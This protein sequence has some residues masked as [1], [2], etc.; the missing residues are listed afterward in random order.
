M[1]RISRAT[2]RM[3]AL[4]LISATLLWA[5]AQ[6]RDVIDPELLRE[7]YGVTGA[8]SDQVPAGE[9]A[10]EA[11]I[12]PITFANGQ[13]GQLI[14][15]KKPGTSA[16]YMRDSGGLHPVALS[17]RSISREEFVRSNPRIVERRAL[18]ESKKKRSW[19]KE[20]LIVGGSAGAGAAIGAVAGGKKGA[21]IGA[22]SG[23]I[24]G[25]VYD[26]ATRK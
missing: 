10:V 8:F 15:P 4:G 13:R 1:N 6:N 9:E 26:L 24:A 5:C 20:V 12:V 17:D 22:L 18:P 2:R 19:E 3:L 21:G 7:K 14:I 23:G 25:L 16:I 11:T